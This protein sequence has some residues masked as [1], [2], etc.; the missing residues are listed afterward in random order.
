MTDSYPRPIDQPLYFKSLNVGDANYDDLVHRTDLRTN[1]GELAPL[2][3]S[4]IPTRFYSHH[5]DGQMCYLDDVVTPLWK[6]PVNLTTFFNTVWGPVKSAEF[7]RTNVCGGRSIVTMTPYPMG[8][9]SI[10]VRHTGPETLTLGEEIYLV[11]PIIDATVHNRIVV[12]ER[13]YY[14]PLIVSR[15]Y[16]TDLLSGPVTFRTNHS[17][18]K[19]FFGNKISHWF[20]AVQN[21]ENTRAR[22]D[23]HLTCF[24]GYTPLADN[25]P[26]SGP[27]LHQTMV[28]DLVAE[29][30]GLDRALVAQSNRQINRISL[31]VSKT[32]LDRRLAFLADLGQMAPL[33]HEN[34]NQFNPHIHLNAPLGNL[35][36][37]L[38]PIGRVARAHTSV[39]E[40]PYNMTQAVKI[41][42]WT[43][44]DI[45]WYQ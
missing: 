23:R 39:S 13:P 37:F 45:I 28:T 42:P 15:R 35:A 18:G 7:S 2:L 26:D 29:S 3:K 24:E 21:F 44:M 34:S 17:Y 36:P 6:M 38:K 16:I 11:P 25:V 30:E 19:T 10:T 20:N 43:D 31:E 8:N 9:R 41:M 1:S 5:P 22:D 32:R 12:G 33:I 4:F 27:F 40:E 14:T